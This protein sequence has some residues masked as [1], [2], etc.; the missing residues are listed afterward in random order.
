MAQLAPQTIVR[1]T[2]AW[3]ERAVIGLNL[4]PF[5][6]AVHARGQVHVTVTAASGPD[7]VLDVLAAEAQALLALSPAE[8]ETTLLVTPDALH[9][10]LDFHDTVVRGERMLRKNKL[11]GVL[12]L[13]SFHPHFQFAGSEPDDIANFT[14]RSPYPTLHLLREESVDK[15]VRAFP[16]AADIYQRNVQTLRRLGPEGWQALGVGA[17]T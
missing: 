3:M 2:V 1:D 9:D 5:A 7:A 17:S 6:K 8:R 12:Q 11:E 14:N 4:C 10:F 13:A 16:D 15:A